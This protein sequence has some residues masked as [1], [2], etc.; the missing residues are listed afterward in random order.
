MAEAKL[1]PPPGAV[2]HGA[3]RESLG[4]GG[5]AGLAVHAGKLGRPTPSCLA[6]GGGDRGKGHPLEP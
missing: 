2:E 1:I 3:C 6:T 4:P 5:V